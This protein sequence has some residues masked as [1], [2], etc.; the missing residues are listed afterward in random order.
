MISSLSA[1]FF[2]FFFSV[3]VHRAV[4]YCC[5][6]SM[7]MVISFKLLVPVERNFP[8]QS[9]TVLHSLWVSG[10]I[11][12]KRVEKK[13]WKKKTMTSIVIMRPK[14]GRTIINQRNRTSSVQIRRGRE[15]T[16]EK[17]SGRKNHR[18]R[19]GSI[20]TH[21]FFFLVFIVLLCRLLWSIRFHFVIILSSFST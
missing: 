10:K 20:Y 3:C 1:T 4:Q 2:F 21:V 7:P 14:N 19:K 6:Q 8:T 16:R 15:W 13:I 12:A 5:C 9:T 11:E 17:K 18:Q